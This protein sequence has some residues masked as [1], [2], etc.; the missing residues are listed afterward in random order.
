M[1][2]HFRDNRL[3]L[4]KFY[5]LKVEEGISMQVHID[6]LRMIVNQLANIENIILMMYGI[7]ISKEF[8]TLFPYLGGFTW[9][10]Y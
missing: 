4:Q 8:V 9:Y 1:Q 7:Y 3:Q 5:N 10:S 2:Q 6:K